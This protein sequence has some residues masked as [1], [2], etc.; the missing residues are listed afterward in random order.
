[1][2]RLLTVVAGI[3]LVPLLLAMLVL[4]AVCGV[5]AGIAYATGG[6]LDRGARWLMRWRA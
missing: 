5:V 2:A 3:G 6:A 4:V 1:M